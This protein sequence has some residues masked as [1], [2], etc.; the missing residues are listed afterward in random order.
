MRSSIRVIF[1]AA[2]VAAVFTTASTKAHAWAWSSTAQYGVW[3]TGGGYVENDEWGSTAYQQVNAN[4][5]SNWEVSGN[6]TGGG[7]KDYPNTEFD[8]SKA[9]NS[10]SAS[11]SFNTSI[12]GGVNYDNSFDIWS[13]GIETMIWNSWNGNQPI[14]ASYNSQGQ[15]VPSWSNVNVGG[16]TYNVY[17]GGNTT[18]FLRTSQT[19]SGSVNIAACLQ[20]E[21]TK[22]IFNN[23]TTTKIQ[24]GFEILDDSYG[25]WFKV[26]SYSLSHN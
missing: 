14:A 24:Y 11:G 8:L 9:V 7:I 1:A 22:G 5:T 2:L 10:L 12:P 25:N 18:S 26:N 20:W 4:S 16:S 21:E 23:P 6:F 19:N 3:S 15:A 13:N 17:H